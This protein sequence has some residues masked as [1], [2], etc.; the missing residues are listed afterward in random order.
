M[1]GSLTIMDLALL[2]R[3]AGKYPLCDKD[4]FLFGFC[5]TPAIVSHAMHRHKRNARSAF[6]ITLAAVMIASLCG[7]QGDMWDA[8]KDMLMATLGCLAWARH[9][10]RKKPSAA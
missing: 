5:F 4:Y 6:Y 7:Q 10:L 3:Y 8:H 2:W 1:H 9:S